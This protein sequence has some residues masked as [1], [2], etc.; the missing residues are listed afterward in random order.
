MEEKVW[1]EDP[2]FE[3][4]IRATFGRVKR[5]VA[6][7]IVGETKLQESINIGLITGGS[8]IAE[9]PPGEG[10]SLTM[11]TYQRV[12]GLTYARIQ[13][14]PDIMPKDI[15]GYREGNIFRKGPIFHQ[16]VLFDEINRAPGKSKAAIL[17]PM[18]TGFV[19]PI[20]W[21]AELP[22]PDPFFVMA[23]MNPTED[24]KVTY[25]LATAELDRFSLR[26][27]TKKKTVQELR[28]VAVRDAGFNLRRVEQVVD[29]DYLRRAIAYVKGASYCSEEHPIVD[30][31]SRLA[32]EMQFFTEEG[33]TSSSPRA[34]RS[35]WLSLV[36]FRILEGVPAITPEHVEY[37][38]RRCWH[39]RIIADSEERRSRILDEALERVSP[40]PLPDG[41]KQ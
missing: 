16:L 15:E 39:H 41:K 14:L 13:G 25:P 1:V 30:Y 20:D 32:R 26:T 3:G 21:N 19:K 34:V 23:T 9:G 7:V 38:I 24:R 29:A 33:E 11:E 27:R 17:N 6:K 12:L 18:Q 37:L 8:V 5:E 31:I 35:F 40:V 22:V 36:A 10:K 2:V 4:E 28:Q